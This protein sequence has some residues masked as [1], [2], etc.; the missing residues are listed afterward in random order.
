MLAGKQIRLRALEP[1]D[2]DLLYGW[3]NDP[4]VW[5]VGD[6][7]MPF[8][9]HTLQRFLDEQ[10]FDFLQ[11]RQQRLIIERSDNGVAVGA[12]DLFELDMLHRRVGVGILIAAEADRRRGYAT[13][14]VEL[15]CDYA[16]E[17]LGLHQVWCN[18]AADNA[19][20]LA[21]FAG[22]GFEPIGLKRDWLWRADGW[23]GEYSLQKIL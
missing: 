11:S 3:E 23:V 18:V 19:A 2:L 9:R 7:L 17:R 12:L 20:S 14:A 15:I 21:L 8:S 13:E 22:C 5:A 6:T 10:Q 4:A 1:H 16:R